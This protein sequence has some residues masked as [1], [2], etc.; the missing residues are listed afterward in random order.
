LAGMEPARVVSLIEAAAQ[1]RLEAKGRRLH[2][3]VAAQGR[4]QAVYQELAR[5]LGYHANAQPFYILAQRLPVRR[6]RSLSVAACEALLFGVA[7]FLEQVRHEET[8][9]ESRRYLRGLWSEWWK[10]LDAASRWLQPWQLPRWRLSGSR[11]GNH[12]QR[13][14]GALAALLAD[15]QR[16]A[17]PLL[18]AGCWNHAAWRQT[19]LGLRHEHWS[20]HYTLL[21]EPAAAPLALVGETRVQEMLANVAYPLL[22]PERPSLWGEY[23]ELPALLDNQRLRRAL[24]RLFGDSTQRG[25]FGKKLFHQQ[26]LLQVYEDFCLEDDSGCRDCPFPERL[27][28]WT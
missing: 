25:L 16:V 6:M 7:G 26:G 3:G 22:V 4:E 9:A 18:D 24:L 19:L 1:F 28:D 8:R 11:P 14:L 21:A 27:A 12:P 15:W 17:A 10:H 23:L 5:A 2:R 13:R 20:T